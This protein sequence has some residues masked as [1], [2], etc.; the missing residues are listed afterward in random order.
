MGS[1]DT[2]DV[3]LVLVAGYVAVT[4]LVR[5]M[6][7]R[8]DVVMRQLQQELQSQPQ[9]PTAVEPGEGTSNSD[10]GGRNDS[11]EAA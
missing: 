4:T 11:K 2:W 9:S 6:R 5:L 7:H 8:R 1:W 3:V 10:E